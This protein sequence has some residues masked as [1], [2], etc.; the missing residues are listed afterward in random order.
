MGLVVKEN[1]PDIGKNNIYHGIIWHQ[2]L[3]KAEEFPLHSRRI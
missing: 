3:T 2:K 1:H